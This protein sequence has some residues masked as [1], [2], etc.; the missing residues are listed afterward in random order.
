M[1]EERGQIPVVDTEDES[2]YTEQPRAEKNT[3]G[4]DQDEG[5]KKCMKNLFQNIADAQ[6]AER[7]TEDVSIT[8][9]D[10]SSRRDQYKVETEAELE[11]QE[12]QSGVR[13]S[14]FSLSGRGDYS[15]S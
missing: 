11:V 9:E 5:Y 2:T 6:Q 7:R 13:D 4:P 10:E 3:A 15:V 1:G 8:L 12:V 14:A